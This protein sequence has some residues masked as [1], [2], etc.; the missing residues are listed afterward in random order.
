MK[1]HRTRPLIKWPSR[2]STHS[3]HRKRINSN[4]HRNS[5]HIDIHSNTHT[6]PKKFIN[7]I[8]IYTLRDTRGKSGSTLLHLLFRGNKWKIMCVCNYKILTKDCPILHEKFDESP[9]HESTIV[10]PIWLFCFVFSFSFE[11]KKKKI[12]TRF[13]KWWFFWM[14]ISSLIHHA[15]DRFSHVSRSLFL[16][17][18]I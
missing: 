16:T 14:R 7:E 10:A 9:T 4:M 1:T 18:A 3:Q 11:K 8:Q 12:N 13:P 5:L 17:F 15:Q 6:P 2:A